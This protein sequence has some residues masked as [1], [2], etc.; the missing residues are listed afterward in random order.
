MPN[1]ILYWFNTGTGG[2]CQ[3]DL[4]YGKVYATGF[5]H[6]QKLM[7]GNKDLFSPDHA[8]LGGQNGA[9]AGQHYS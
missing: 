1:T 2:I 8:G 7:C 3:R 6:G 9:D 5:A 4:D